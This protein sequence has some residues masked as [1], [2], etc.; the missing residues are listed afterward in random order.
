MK[1]AAKSEVPVVLTFGDSGDPH[2]D[3]GVTEWGSADGFGVEIQHR[4]AK[5]ASVQKQIETELGWFSG[6]ERFVPPR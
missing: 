1:S 2:L 4:A 3:P 6:W 5:R